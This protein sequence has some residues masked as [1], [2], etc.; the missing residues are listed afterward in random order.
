MGEVALV[1][2]I[3]AALGLGVLWWGQRSLMYFPSGEAAPPAARVIA[4]AEDV[5]L[6]TR[7]G[8]RLGAYFVRGRGESPRPAVLVANGNAGDRSDRV[9]LA[10]ALAG[11]GHSVLV[12]DYRGYGGNPGS[13]SE[14]GLL[15]D[16]RAAVDHLRERP[17][18]D[19]ARIA[20]FGESLGSGVVTALAVERSPSAL[21]L[22]S[23]FTSFADIG[24]HHYPWLPVAPLVRD[25]YPIDAQIG[26]VRVPVLVIAGDADDIVPVRFSR[27][28]HE[29][30]A[31]P[32]RLVVLT[33]VG[34][35]DPELLAGERMIAA[36][37]DFL[38]AAE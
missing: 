14:Q 1:V 26:N 5:E 3:A 23:P 38:E 37:I 4:G 35:N 7:D 2:V 30:A 12:F 29:K 18:V 6:V 36:I 24:S 19:P 11:F 34:H 31:E 33:G 16:A 32:K 27:A 10:S 25:R 8:L 17:D 20:Y 13:P 21:I 22:R 15:D 28:V 9:P